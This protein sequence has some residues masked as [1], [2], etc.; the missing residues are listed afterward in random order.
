MNNLSEDVSLKKEIVD[1]AGIVAGSNWLNRILVFGT[2]IIVVRILGPELYGSYALGRRIFNLIMILAVFGLDSALVKFVPTARNRKENHELK[3]V[4]ETSFFWGAVFACLWAAVLILASPVLE[5]TYD[6]PQLK[7]ILFV[8]AL[9]LPFA[10]LIRLSSGY[11]QGE[12]RLDYLALVDSIMPPPVKLLAVIIFF[13]LG[14]RLHSVLLGVFLST[15][16]PAL[17]CLYLLRTRF[18]FRLFRARFGVSRAATKKIFQFSSVLLA[19]QFLAEGIS[20]VDIYLVGYFLVAAQVGIY[21]VVLEIALLFMVIKDSFSKI[22]APMISEAWERGD[23][24]K[25]ADLYKFQAKIIF[26]IITPFFLLIFLYPNNILYLFGREFEAGKMALMILALGQLFSSTVG[27]AGFILTMA[28]RQ[29]Y[30]LFNTLSILFVSAALNYVLIQKY[31]MN[32]AAA[33]ASASLIIVNMMGIIQVK[34]IYG[35]T[36][37]KRS[38]WKPLAAGSLVYAA[39]KLI[40][41][42]F[43]PWMHFV[44]ACIG[45][46]LLYFLVLY[47]LGLEKD[48]SAVLKSYFKKIPFRS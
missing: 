35:F 26:T 28:G 39:F 1:K 27:G 13:L 45:L 7:L 14:Y 15:L 43:L 9:S 22:F 5:K 30:Q 44:A 36:F 48:E 32:G 11:F 12:R 31:G 46:A 40:S 20:R 41:P 38:F 8:F 6:L 2:S 16:V 18:D 47:L 19:I 3:E 4:S 10:V 24:S 34:L 37:F 21:G 42:D 33:A 25:I 29:V 17:T 23:V